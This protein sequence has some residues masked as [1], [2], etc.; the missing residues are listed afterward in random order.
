MDAQRASIRQKAPLIAVCVSLILFYILIVP[1]AEQQ[2]Q[3]KNPRFLPEPFRHPIRPLIE[4]TKHHIYGTPHFAIL[5]GDAG[6]NIAQQVGT[7]LD[8]QVPP[9]P[10]SFANNEL[11]VV[12][13]QVV[14][15]RDVYIIQAMNMHPNRTLRQLKLL[16]IGAKGRDANRIYSIFTH[17]P[18]AR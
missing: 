18:Y 11:R 13:P 2:R 3:P 12:V 5:A 17:L 14:E 7:I 16:G 15:T 6:M 4:R 10:P 1:M 9:N 8:K